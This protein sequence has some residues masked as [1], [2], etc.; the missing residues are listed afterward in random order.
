MK[1]R[2]GIDLERA[3]EAEVIGALALSGE[4]KHRN[5]PDTEER[6]T[7]AQSH[8]LSDLVHSLVEVAREAG[9][10]QKRVSVGGISFELR[11]DG[12]EEILS[13]RTAGGV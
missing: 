2:V 12:A 6:F 13:I 10:E 3:A 7:P 9:A 11:D 8:A 4:R 5:A 1:R